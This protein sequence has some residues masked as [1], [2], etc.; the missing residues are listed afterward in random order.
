M[1]S[2]EQ[3]LYDLVTDEVFELAG[4]ADYPVQPN[5]GV[6]SFLEGF[7][8]SGFFLDIDKKGVAFFATKSI[9]GQALELNT[10]LTFEEILRGWRN[11]PLGS[12]EALYDSICE[13]YDRMG[14]NLL[15]IKATTAEA[16]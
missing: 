2:I 4:R 6:W 14:R 13:V 11:H 8:A 3:D 5:I 1:D 9:G 7:R 15:L 16:I 12:P 10:R